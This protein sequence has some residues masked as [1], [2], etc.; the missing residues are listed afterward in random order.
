VA[1]FPGTNTS[2]DSQED[3]T[4]GSKSF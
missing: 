1:M 3:N 4:G 2:K